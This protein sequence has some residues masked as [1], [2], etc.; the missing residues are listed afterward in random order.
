MIL[1]AIIAGSSAYFLSKDQT[2]IYRATQKVLIQPS[3]TDFGLAEASRLLLN[4]LVVYLNTETIADQIIQELKLDIRS[5]EL[6]SKVT[7]A[8][9]QLS[10]VV[11]I[12][13]DSPRGDEAVRI[14][15]AWGQKLVD[16]RNQENAK[17]RREDRV[18]AILIDPG[19]IHPS[20]QSPKPKINAVAGGILGLLV[21]GIIVFIMEYLES[22]IVRRR[23]D[24]ERLVD[25]PVL[26]TIPD[27]D[28]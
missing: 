9:D 27:F 14:A 3:R 16:Y 6:K 26:A 7:I 13:V 22:S 25:V 8:P 21:G 18:N 17:A 15:N 10:M 2:P 1:L 5:G 28:N 4:P 23:E 12:D 11:Q 20:Q 19:F 24:L